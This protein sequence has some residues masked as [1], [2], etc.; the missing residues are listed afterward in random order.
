MKWGH[1]LY[2]IIM[3]LKTADIQHYTRMCVYWLGEVLLT[4]FDMKTK[5]WIINSL[6]KNNRKVKRRCL[7]YRWMAGRKNN[8]QGLWTHSSFNGRHVR[9]VFHNNNERALELI[10]Q[11][12]STGIYITTYTTFINHNYVFK[13]F[14]LFCLR[15]LLFITIVM[16][17]VLYLFLHGI[18]ITQLNLLMNTYL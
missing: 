10:P 16:C 3:G 2:W 18:E 12:A 8:T 5:Q 11:E 7:L 17:Y 4:K 6:I 13:V 1:K 15:N 14:F 9:G